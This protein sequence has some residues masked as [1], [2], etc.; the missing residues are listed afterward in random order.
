MPEIGEIRK[1][2]NNNN[3]TREKKNVRYTFTF[4]LTYS[5]SAISKSPML[6]NVNIISLAL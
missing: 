2:K 4:F 6:V 1:K 5:E 3:N